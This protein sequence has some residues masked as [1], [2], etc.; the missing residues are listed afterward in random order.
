MKKS[1]TTT[2]SAS[3]QLVKAHY[4]QRKRILVIVTLR[5]SMEL[6]LRQMFLAL[7][8]E[9][10][11][12]NKIMISATQLKWKKF[13]ICSTANCVRLKCVWKGTIL[14][15]NK[16]VRRVRL[17][18]EMRTITEFVSHMSD[19]KLPRKNLDGKCKQ[20]KRILSTYLRTNKL[21]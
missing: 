13:K 14:E 18:L 2:L 20:R 12:R 3:P 8:R 21:S 4:L 19:F 15:D 7:Q 1:S 6:I 5:E 17:F 16:I 9:Y 10:R 11:Q